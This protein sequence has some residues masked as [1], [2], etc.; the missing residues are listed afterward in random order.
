VRL[1]LDT[2]VLLWAITDSPKMPTH[3]RTLLADPSAQLWVSVASLWEITIK[4]ALG[5][6]TMPV[7]G[8]DAWAWVQQAGF[9]QLTVQAPHVLA[10]ADLPPLHG[11]PFDR[12]LV[13]Q[14]LTEPMRLVT[15]D[16]TVARYSDTI[17]KV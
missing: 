2:H 3:A 4:H 5:R 8:S 15:H 17:L 16:A 9:A 12:L 7:S 11:D 10:A 13:A 6:G 14:A 1:L